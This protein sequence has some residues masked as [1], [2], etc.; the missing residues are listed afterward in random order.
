RIAIRDAVMN[1]I[2]QPLKLGDY[3]R[4][5]RRHFPFILVP[6]L[7]LGLAA[8]GVVLSLPALCRSTRKIAADSQQIA[9]DLVRSTVPGSANRRV[10]AIQQ[11]VMTDARRKGLLAKF[12]LFQKNF[13]ALPW[14][15]C[16]L[17]SETIFWE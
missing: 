5:I 2:P 13:A 9:V 17:G 4:I 14:K 8:T 1:N 11:I 7:I 15:P 10:G 6:F 12:K 3:F 16:W